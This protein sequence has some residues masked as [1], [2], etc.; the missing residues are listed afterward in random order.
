MMS[1]VVYYSVINLGSALTY[2]VFHH[3]PL[4]CGGA[5]RPILPTL[6]RDTRFFLVSWC[7]EPYGSNFLSLF[8]VI[9][10]TLMA[11]TYCT[12]SHPFSEF[13]TFPV[14]ATWYN[15]TKRDHSSK[16]KKVGL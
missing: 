14:A 12:S 11:Q 7:G 2:L 5:E 1:C 8:T 3:H 6:C 10:V 13:L 9:L 15:L 16:N 4:S